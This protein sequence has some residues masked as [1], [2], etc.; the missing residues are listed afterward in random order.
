MKSK[1]KREYAKVLKEEGVESTRLKARPKAGQMAEENAR[2]FGADVGAGETSDNKDTPG[3]GS[4]L[5]RKQSERS[6]REDRRP[7]D[8]QK[9]EGRD[10]RRPDGERGGKRQHSDRKARMDQPRKVR[11]LSPGDIGP[12]MPM[13]NL[14]ELKKEAFKKYHP[15]KPAPSAKGASRSVSGASDTT[16]NSAGGFGGSLARV[17][18]GASGSS[19]GGTRKGQPNMAARMG[20][21]LEQIKRDRS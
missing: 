18:S 20:A 21:L 10:D 6:D 4:S 14:R 2:P 17:F 8:G 12:P 9:R 3:R 11:A 16:R 1:L 15:A 5:K 7:K 13:D 19:A